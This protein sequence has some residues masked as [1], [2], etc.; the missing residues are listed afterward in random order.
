MSMQKELRND[1]V[2][3]G[4]RPA[5]PWLVAL[6][7]GIL[8][9]CIFSVNFATNLFDLGHSETPLR[10]FQNFQMDSEMSV[11]MMLIKTKQDGLWSTGGIMM[12]RDVKTLYPRAFGLQGK[13]FSWL[14]RSS[15]SDFDTFVSHAHIGVSVL[16]G[17]VLGA[18]VV[19]V[20]REWGF[21]AALGLI[22][23]LNLSDWI[24]FVGRNL[25]CVY[26]LKFLPLVLAFFLFEWAR[27]GEGWSRWNAYLGIVGLAVLADS[28]CIA[29][30]STN[31]VLSVGAV[32][33]YFGLR[34]QAPWPRIAGWVTGLVGV[35]LVATVLALVLTAVQAGL[36]YHSMGSGFRDIFGAAST[37]MYAH[38]NGMRSA[39]PGVSAFRIFEQY[40]TLPV[41]SVPGDD[42]Q[43]YRVYTSL[44]AAIGLLVPAVLAVFL[45]G[46]RFH[47]FESERRRLIGLAGATVW[48]LG[49]SLSWAFLLKGHMWHHMHL[50]GVIF[51]VPYLVLLY[52]LMGKLVGAGVVQ[53]WHS[54][55]PC[56]PERKGDAACP[57]P[58]RTRISS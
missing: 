44:F 7:L 15:S 9:A 41:I 6:S 2:V 48:G 8:A 14:Y 17:L 32:P 47:I 1:D 54:L 36:H 43:R 3:T 10:S 30:P 40:L 53:A 25:F 26:A 49:A 28:L 12:E 16:F 52:V 38:D 55:L 23:C 34:D 33:V 5:R 19:F 27:R 18:L 58:R 56:R 21:G 50:N 46:R 29:W 35:A 39:P 11:T 57:P 22:V 20:A 51:Y 37:R 42:A 24:V 31:V 45:D 4:T 13:V